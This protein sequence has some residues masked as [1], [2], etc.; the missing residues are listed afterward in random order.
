MWAEQLRRYFQQFLTTVKKHRDAVDFIRKHRLWEGFWDYGFV[1]RILVFFAVIAGFRFLMIYFKWLNRAAGSDPVA[2][3]SSIGT[4][5]QDIFQDGYGFLL[6]GGMK[7]VLMIL[8]EVIIFH[9]SRRTVAILTSKDSDIS[10][11]S[12][13]H[14]Q[15]RMIKVVI[16]SYIMEMIAI[17]LIKVFFNIFGFIDFIQ[18]VVILAA[19]CYFVG[20]AVLDNYFEQFGQT[21]EQSLK[22]TRNYVGV[23]LAAGLFLQ[24][25]FSIPVIGAVGGPFIATVAVTLVLFELSDLHRRP[26]LA[27]ALDPDDVV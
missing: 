6:Q 19:Q 15:M 1:A 2:M 25:A 13:L 24:L 27:P 7:Y 11:Q 14:A 8:V 16:A 4:L 22:L 18:P 12:F 20:F 17:M 23:A 10:F 21:I 26:Q 5:F 9:V 3:I